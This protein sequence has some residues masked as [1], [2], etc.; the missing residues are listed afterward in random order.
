MDDAASRVR[1][2]LRAKKKQKEKEKA[3]LKAETE[4]ALE[5][6]RSLQEEG[7]LPECYRDYS[8]DEHFRHIVQCSECNSV[9][10]CA[11]VKRF[12]EHGRIDDAIEAAENENRRLKELEELD[13][14][15]GEIQQ[16]VEHLESVNEDMP[17]DPEITGGPVYTE[18]KEGDAQP[19]TKPKWTK[20]K[21]LDL[22]DKNDEAV[23]RAVVNIY[24]RQTP[25]EQHTKS[26]RNVNEMGFNKFDAELMSSF[27]EQ[28][29]KWNNTA[30]PR[31]RKPLS[32]K[33]MSIA[34]RKIKKYWRQLLEI[35]NG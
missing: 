32:Q 18:T 29:I 27:A 20:E 26:T 19:E 1:A 23:T 24:K 22:L 34:R 21:I 14:S 31:F 12:F 10:S 16:D 3:K 6:I 28:I 2:Q 35:A 17:G 13:K 4:K 11:R 9:A 8:Q 15:L 30:S 7:Y 33:Q 25:T 5:E